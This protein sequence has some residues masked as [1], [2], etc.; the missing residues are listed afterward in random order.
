MKLQT[1]IVLLLTAAA[2]VS[3]CASPDLQY[4]GNEHVLAPA[5][6]NENFYAVIDSIESGPAADEANATAQA[7]T[8]GALAS[9]ELGKS[10]GRQE[11]YFIRVRFDDRTYRMVTQTSLEGLRVGDSVRIE[12]GRVRR[13]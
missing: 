4:A 3:G 10:N 11:A 13:Y 5:H 9:H 2:L 7:T 8:E 6:S 1:I 12:N